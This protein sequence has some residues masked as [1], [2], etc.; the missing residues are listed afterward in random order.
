MV[1]EEIEPEG[2]HAREVFANF[3]LAMYT[4]QVLEHGM[5]NVAHWTSIDNRTISTMADFDEDNMK[6][7]RQTMG[8]LKRILMDRRSDIDHLE[9][10]LVRAVQLRNFLAHEYFRQRAAA[11][12]TDEGKVQMIEELRSAVSFFEE[13]DAK[14][15]PLT[16]QML[17]SISVDKHMPEALESA[18]QAGFGEPLPGLHG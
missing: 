6:L 3:G 14:L 5:I 12:L 7:F 11:F 1:V 2:W 15:E 9:D 10:L 18:R 16:A 4:A 8:Q 13:I 17:S